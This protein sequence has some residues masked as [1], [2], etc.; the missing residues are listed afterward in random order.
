MP[1]MSGYYQRRLSREDLERTCYGAAVGNI[2]GEEL[3]KTLGSDGHLKH[4]IR[5]RLILWIAVR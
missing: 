5:C 4:L 1:A 3:E 2:G